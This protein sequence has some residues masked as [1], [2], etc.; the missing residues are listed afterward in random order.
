MYKDVVPE[1]GALVNEL[2]N[3]PILVLAI[4]GESLVV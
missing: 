2:S 1:Y 3:G 4:S